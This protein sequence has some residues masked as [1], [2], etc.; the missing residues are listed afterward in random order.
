MSL[1][2]FTHFQGIDA[3][4]VFG[5]RLW[6]VAAIVA[7]PVYSIV[8]GAVLTPELGAV[9]M[10]AEVNTRRIRLQLLLPE[11]ASSACVN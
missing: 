6:G 10:C 7:L 9:Q 8:Q 11:P 4:A 2:S 5:V 3:R 1:D